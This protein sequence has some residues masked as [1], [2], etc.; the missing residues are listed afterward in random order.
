MLLWW[1]SRSGVKKPGRELPITHDAA[2][3]ENHDEDEDDP[4][5]DLTRP[6]ERRDGKAP[7]S[8]PRSRFRSTSLA[9]VTTITPTTAPLMFC[10]PPMTSMEMSEKVYAI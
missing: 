2:R 6:V 3:A 10:M 9:S 1:S 5:H 4:Q 7:K 8:T